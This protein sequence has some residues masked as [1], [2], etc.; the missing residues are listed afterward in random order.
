MFERTVKTL[1]LKNK[2]QSKGY[3]LPSV[4]FT[5]LTTQNLLHLLDEKSKKFCSPLLSRGKQQDSAELQ[6]K[7]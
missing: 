7:I 6:L 3:D 5:N 4:I 1:L 2:E